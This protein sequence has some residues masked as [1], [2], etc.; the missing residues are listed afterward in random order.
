MI[1]TKRFD[2]FPPDWWLRRRSRCVRYLFKN[3]F[4]HKDTSIIITEDYPRGGR[5]NSDDWSYP[6]KEEGWMHRSLLQT[7]LREV[8]S[9]CF[10]SF[11]LPPNV[12]ALLISKIS[13]AKSGKAQFGED[14]GA[15]GVNV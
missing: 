4:H 14:T 9:G 6:P 3:Q 2:I 7:A 12:P 10:G 15:S 13:L 1:P 11:A 8:P 5:Y